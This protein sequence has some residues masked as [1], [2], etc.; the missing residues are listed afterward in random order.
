[1]T[2]HV[3]SIPR[4]A[5]RADRAAPGNPPISRA[6]A[7]GPLTVL[8]L[9]TIA[10]SRA[11]AAD[12]AS[13][14]QS[15]GPR[16]VAVE[17]GFA[18]HFKV[19]YWTPVVV[20]V[21]AGAEPL[22]GRV[23]LVALD[24]D[25]ALSRVRAEGPVTIA[26]A[27]RASQLVYVKIGQLKSDLVVDFRAESGGL[28]ATRRFT[29]TDPQLAGI[30]PSGQ[31]LIVAVGLS[32]LA[33]DV[34]RLTQRGAA[35]AQ[36][37]SIDALPND[38][39]GLEGASAVLLAADAQVASKLS[40]PSPQLAA[41]TTWVK[42]GGRLVLAV[43]V[44]APEVLQ[45]GSPL[46]ELAPGK[47]ESLVPL[48][49]GTALEAFVDT[50]EPLSGAG[51]LDL[52]VP[53]LLEAR[54]R[55]EAYEGLHSRDLPMVVRTPHGFG[56]VTFAAFDLGR[57]PLAEWKGRAALFDRLLRRRVAESRERIRNAGPGHHA[58]FRRHRRP[59]AGALDQFQGIELVPFWL[60]AL[61][62]TAY[63][64]CIGPLDY[65]LVKR[66][67]RRM[68]A[69]WLTFTVTVVLFSAGAVALAYGLKGRELVI[70][71]VDVVDFDADSSLI[72][73][74]TWLN[75][76]SPRIDTYDLSLGVEPAAGGAAGATRCSRGWGCPA[77][78]S[79]G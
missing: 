79:G 33:A 18:G 57:P 59:T 3:A 70:N 34:E 39:W 42:M 64:V 40:A 36:L 43:G 47:F 12:E 23:E 4:R 52:R 55:I 44:E 37:E 54:G 28:L 73:G 50:N 5:V 29:T 25:G 17:A 53:K 49:R 27:G 19:G 22:E 35:V 6:R 7:I 68:E 51:P 32:L 16:I 76:Y 60:V 15:R 78:V 56:E 62:S 48:R 20:T 21:E 63:I 77:A 1:M 10:S 8:L 61:L 38:W 24:G 72:R 58:G 45:P 71:H 2:R 31:E 67:L 11:L 69:T 46:A 30:E 9:A 41:L 75:L 66:V 26:A 14:G 74:T 13:A 65:Y